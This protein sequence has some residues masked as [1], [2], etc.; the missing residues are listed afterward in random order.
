MP[1]ENELGPILTLAGVS[2]FYESIPFGAEEN[3][4][5]FIVFYKHLQ[6]RLDTINPFPRTELAWG[7]S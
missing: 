7:Y 4:M 5:V 2:R 6:H 3:C 1:V